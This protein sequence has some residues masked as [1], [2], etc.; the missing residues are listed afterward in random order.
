MQVRM[1]IVLSR[2][3][4][5]LRPAPAPLGSDSI[6]PD[7][8]VRRRGGPKKQLHL[9]ST[10]WVTLTWCWVAAEGVR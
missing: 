7:G 8:S 5:R 9:V 4:L 3:W 10:I 6:P 2:E 1:S